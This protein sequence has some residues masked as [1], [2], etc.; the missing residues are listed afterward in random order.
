[1][2]LRRKE[3]NQLGHIGN[4]IDSRHNFTQPGLLSC[5][6]FSIF[7]GYIKKVISGRIAHPMCQRTKQKEGHSKQHENEYSMDTLFTLSNH[8]NFLYDCIFS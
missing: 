5:L 2:K 8:Y 1:M 3:N 4:W 7:T 6:L